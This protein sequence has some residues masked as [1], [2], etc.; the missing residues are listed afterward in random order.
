MSEQA[1]PSGTPAKQTTPINVSDEP[2]DMTPADSEDAPAAT[3]GRSRARVVLFGVLAAVMLLVMVAVG[4]AAW[5]ITQ[6]KDAA[7]V[8][9]EQLAGL[10][11]DDSE[12]ALR[13]AD[14][15]RNALAAEVDLDSTLGVVY[16]DAA[17]QDPAVLLFGGTT[18]IWTPES[19][20]DTAFELLSDDTGS[21]N[22]LRAVDAGPLGGVMKCGNTSSQDGPM[23]VCGWADH[24]SLV[25]AMF[26]DRN[27]Q[28]AAPVMKALRGGVQTRL[29]K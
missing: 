11:R 1:A 10:T 28:E 23:A 14:Y 4:T 17:R 7:L 16:A 2:F 9:P 21:L 27:A 13:T 12:N 29:S 22:D 20:L 8:P 5:R 3:P 24:G 19:D 25:L 26:P 6:Q 18:L 15:L